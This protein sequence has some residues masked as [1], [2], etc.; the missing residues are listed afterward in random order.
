MNIGGKAFNNVID[1]YSFN[2]NI[3]IKARRDQQG[4]RTITK[5]ITSKPLTKRKNKHIPIIIISVIGSYIYA[6]YKNIENWRFKC[7]IILVLIWITILLYFIIIS[8]NKSKEK[9][10]NKITFIFLYY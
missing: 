4:E 9:N 10:L 7:L 3:I 2:E 5:E 1:F 6:Y 8:K